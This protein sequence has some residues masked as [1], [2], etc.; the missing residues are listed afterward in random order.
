[1][2]KK[3]KYDG[4][5]QYGIRQSTFLTNEGKSPVVI[6]PITG[7]AT[8][9]DVLMEKISRRS[10][11]TIHDL[12]AALSAI[13][14]Q[15]VEEISQGRAVNLGDIGFFAPRLG[16][17]GKAYTADEVENEKVKVEGVSFRPSQKIKHELQKI[18]CSYSLMCNAATPEATDDFEDKVK[19]YLEKHRFI[20][21]PD[22]ARQMG[23]SRSTTRRKL[24]EL[25][26]KR[27]IK[28]LSPTK[29]QKMYVLCDE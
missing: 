21:T 8:E 12:K 28:D 17:E 25:E 7:Q 24:S 6:Y 2:V 20:T 16:Y 29:K 3:H 14:E 10:T 19:K 18:A 11:L 13:G 5:L 23:M 26:Q 27:V 22:F 4:R 15:I 9:D 1:M